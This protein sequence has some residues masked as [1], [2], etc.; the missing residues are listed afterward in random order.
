MN[1]EQNKKPLLPE[2]MSLYPTMNDV[3]D[4]YGLATSRLPIKTQNEVVSI[5]A[6]YH[7]TLLN[8]LSKIYNRN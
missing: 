4:V 5:L 2:N 6:T 7:N 1:P 3:E 8:V